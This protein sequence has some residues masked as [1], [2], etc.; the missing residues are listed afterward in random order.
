MTPLTKQ[1]IQQALDR[2]VSSITARMLS[3]SDV[4]AI[5]GA[6][7]TGVL[8]DLKEL[9]H[10]NQT[11]IRN[12]QARHDQV[13]QRLTILERNIQSLVYDMAKVIDTTSRTNSTVGTQ[14]TSNNSFSFQRI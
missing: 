5:I 4:Q 14:P 3:K 11:M 2:N 13:N 9:H 8:Q 6:V 12:G 10:E 7:R 1:D